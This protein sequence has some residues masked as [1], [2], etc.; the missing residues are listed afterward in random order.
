MDPNFQDKRLENEIERQ[1]LMVPFLRSQPVAI[2]I[3]SSFAVGNTG[4]YLV[5]KR[6]G[7]GG[8]IKSHPDTETRDLDYRRMMKIRKEREAEERRTLRKRSISSLSAVEL[9]KL[10]AVRH[11]L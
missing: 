4:H 2:P 3:T 9:R 1:E 8:E 7:M 11:R 10:S 5:G 6:P